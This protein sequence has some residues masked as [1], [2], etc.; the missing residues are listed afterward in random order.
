MLGFEDMVQDYLVYFIVLV[1]F[2]GGMITFSLAKRDVG[3]HWEAIYADLLVHAIA[4]AQPGDLIRLDFSLP[5]AL[6]VRA[7]VSFSSLVRIVPETRQV[8]THFGKGE[9]CRL[10]VRSYKVVVRTPVSEEPGPKELVLEV[11]R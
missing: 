7:G 8:C 4:Q 1:V 5:A 10:Y 9:T 6:A 2:V 3:G 11:V